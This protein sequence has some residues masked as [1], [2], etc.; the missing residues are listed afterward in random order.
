[1]KSIAIFL[2]SF[3][4]S[5]LWAQYPAGY[6]YIIFRGDTICVRPVITDST[7]E[8]EW[9]DYASSSMHTGHESPYE[10]HYFFFYNPMTGNLGLVM[11]HNI[12]E[13]G[14]ANA[15]CNLWLDGLP[16]GC[17]FAMSDDMSHGHSGSTGRPCGSAQEF[18]MSCYPQGGWYWLDNTDGGAFYLPREEFEFPFRTVFGGTDPIQ[19]VYFLSGDFGEDRIYL[20]YIILGDEDTVIVGHNFQGILTMTDTFDIGCL[21]LGSVETLHVSVCNSDETSDTFHF[22]SITPPN[23]VYFTLLY[24]PTELA[25]GECDEIILLFHP[26]DTGNI[27]DYLY[28]DLNT[29]CDSFRTLTLIGDVVR[30]DLDPVWFWEETDCDSQNVVTICYE[31][32]ECDTATITV[33]FSGDG[34]ISWL[35][36]GTGWFVTL[37]DTSGDFGAGIQPGV[38]CFEWLMSADLPDSEACSFILRVIA[39]SSSAGYD[40]GSAAGCLDSHNPEV[41][42]SCPSIVT[43]GENYWFTWTIDDMFWTNNLSDIHIFGC[44]LDIF[45]TVAGTSY[46]WIVPLISC[47]SCTLVIAVRDSFCNWGYDTCIF[48]IECLPFIDRIWFSEETDCDDRNIVE[49]CYDLFACDS[50]PHTVSIEMFAD[51]ALTEN[52]PLI[53]ISDETGDIGANVYPGLH[54]F[55]WFMNI[56][57]PDSESCE[58]A[59]RAI[60]SGANYDT[61][62]AY[63]CL[64]SRPPD[65]QIF[66]PVDLEYLTGDSLNTTWTVGDMFWNNDPGSLIV[67][68]DMM[69]DV[70]AVY[71]T[72][73]WWEIPYTCDSIELQIEVR[74]S[75]CNW[76]YD[77]CSFLAC[78]RLQAWLDCAPCDM[79]SSCST[80]SISLW[81]ADTICGFKLDTTRVFMQA[82]IY[83]PD[84][85]SDYYGPLD[86]L[87]FQIL[88]DSTL[89][90]IDYF[91]FIDG[92]EFYIS[93]DS[94]FSEQGCM[95]I[96]R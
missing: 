25:P 32:Q 19:N 54:C 23:P 5:L 79:F 40:T 56:D 66:C 15:T 10:T 94:M 61:I 78:S 28:I 30:G 65:V 46:N 81:V 64:D 63:G 36:T 27:I 6:F 74:D 80:Q 1:L 71:D 77:T 11:Q 93:L 44:G 59:V 75:F 13:G 42:I 9:F 83:H 91:N 45:Q 70:F 89:I 51:H 68:Y 76:G 50:V 29:P 53:T 37:M 41:S 92:D 31:Y 60:L 18:N 26:P 17:T 87:F 52:I 88:G 39:N 34:G 38:H 95:T 35:E 85:S 67:S 8:A 90:I 21:T 48:E 47:P 86:S 12:D 43:A 7:T 24:A 58:F 62:V 4:A 14:T 20:H 3:C 55:N 84:G 2:L 82:I 72:H 73:Y 49:I 96:P 33:Q 22:G 57:L 16:A 69:S